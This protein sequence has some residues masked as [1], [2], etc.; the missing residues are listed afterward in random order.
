M[1]KRDQPE[2]RAIRVWDVEKKAIFAE[3]ESVSEAGDKLGLQHAHVMNNA[4]YK[5]INKT[6]RF[7]LKLAIRYAPASKL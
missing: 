6:N 3:Y 5:R 1:Q 2:K 7:G 4:K